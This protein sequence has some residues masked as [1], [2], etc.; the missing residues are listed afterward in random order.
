MS[1]EQTPVQDWK[2]GLDAEFVKTLPE[3]YV[4]KFDGKPTSDVLKSHVELEKAFG[5]KI[6]GMV[7]LPTEQSTPEEIAAFHKALGVPD[8]IEGYELAIPEADKDAFESIAGI[9]KA[10][11]LESGVAPK[12]LSNVWGKVVE[13]MTAQN[14]ALEEKGLAM[15]KADEESLKTEWG[16]KFEEN[17]A[18]VDKVYGKL[19]TGNDL[20]GIL[21]TF[22]LSNHPAVKK[23]FLELAPLVVEGK[24]IIGS[25][26]GPKPQTITDELPNTAKALGWQ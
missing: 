11:A 8:K 9:V 10:A 24:T 18:V 13:A 20:K 12:S 22:G 16:A 19:N 17:N 23:A 25:G 3:S 15:M 4:K 14:K 2:T 7:K 5:K 21:E 6:E 26:D 1:E